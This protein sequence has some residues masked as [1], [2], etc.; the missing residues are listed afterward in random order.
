MLDA[1]S[2]PADPMIRGISRGVRH[3]QVSTQE[4]HTIQIEAAHI[5]CR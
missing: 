1:T 2:L 3:V 4:S 5:D